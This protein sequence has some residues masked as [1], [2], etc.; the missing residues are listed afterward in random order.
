MMVDVAFT[1]ITITTTI[2]PST[3]GDG[4]RSH[5]MHGA[6]QWR[7]QAMPCRRNKTH[8]IDDM[9]NLLTFAHHPP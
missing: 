9:P 7:P 5:A 3:P 2:S 6:I 4:G 1:V 8:I